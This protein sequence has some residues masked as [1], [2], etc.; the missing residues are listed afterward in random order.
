[1]DGLPGMK[2]G[3]AAGK[4]HKVVPIKKMVGPLA[5][6]RY[7]KS[8]YTFQDLVLVAILCLLVG[9]LSAR[10]GPSVAEQCRE[11]V[12]VDLKVPTPFP[13]LAEWR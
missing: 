7:R 9:I 8:F 10:Y 3:L 12:P 13:S 11:L 5:P 1:M 6:T 2:R 4:E